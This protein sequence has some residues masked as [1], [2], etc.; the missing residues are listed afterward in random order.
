MKLELEPKDLEGETP[1]SPATDDE[2][3]DDEEGIALHEL[4][5][6]EANCKLYKVSKVIARIT[7]I[8]PDAV[9][10]QYI[11]KTDTGFQLTVCRNCLPHSKPSGCVFC[12]V[13]TG[14][15]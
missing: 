15:C 6:Q 9:S 14:F 12:C 11:Q 10:C 4:K 5:E 7:K 1:S 2:S 3:D 13:I 8:Q